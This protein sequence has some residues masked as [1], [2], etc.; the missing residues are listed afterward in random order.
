M[1]LKEAQM[2]GVLALIAVGIILLCMWGGQ[3]DSAAPTAKAEQ[4]K[5]SSQPALEPDLA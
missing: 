3:G 4:A 1:K 2:L 5:A